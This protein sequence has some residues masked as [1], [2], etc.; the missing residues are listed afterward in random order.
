MVS[1]DLPVPP[2]G[3]FKP[4]SAAPDDLQSQCAPIGVQPVVAQ[5]I[6]TVIQGTMILHES[7][8][9]G[10]IRHWRCYVWSVSNLFA[11]RKIATQKKQQMG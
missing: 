3:R 2:V 11:T 9:K 4:I 5:S 1:L 10:E 8:E 6:N 7:K